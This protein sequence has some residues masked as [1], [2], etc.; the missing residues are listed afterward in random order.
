MPNNHI[1]STDNIP[2]N[3]PWAT[4]TTTQK[5]YSYL[6]SEDRAA[7]DREELIKIMHTQNMADKKFL[8]GIIVLF[9]VLLLLFAGIQG[10]K[11]FL[12]MF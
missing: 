3:V 11:L 6:K 12:G 9:A 10:A 5:I 4:Y 7:N 1:P 8:K 2:I